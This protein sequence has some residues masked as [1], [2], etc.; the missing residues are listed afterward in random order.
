MFCALKPIYGGTEG[1][2]SRFHVL[3]SKTHYWQYHGRLVQFSYFALSD[4]F[5][6]VPREPG[7]VLMIYTSGVIFDGTEGNRSS[8]QVFRSRHVF[9]SIEGAGSSFLV[10][11]TRTRFRQNQPVKFS[12]FSLPDSFSAVSRVSG[13]IFKVYA[14]GIRNAQIP[15]MLKLRKDR[16]T[17]NLLLLKLGIKVCRII[18][19]SYRHL[20]LYKRR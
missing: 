10:L 11:R 19:E 13:S 14:A 4:S 17:K 5:L 7:L 8:F 18:T 12:C 2:G 20:I 9:N 3:L 1:A 15:L 16:R 6:A